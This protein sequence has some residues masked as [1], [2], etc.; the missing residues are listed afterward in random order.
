MGED[1]GRTTDV[2]H[3]IANV[4]CIQ[5]MA[6]IQQGDSEHYKYDDD[7]D[8]DNDDED[9]GEDDDLVHA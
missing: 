2:A 1:R 6:N 3:W 8:D 5:C 7:D 9:D 4:H